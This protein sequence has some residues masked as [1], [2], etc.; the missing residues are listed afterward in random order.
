MCNKNGKMW[1][2]VIKQ[3]GA[4]EMLSVRKN[5][6]WLYKTIRKTIGGYMENVYPTGLPRGFVMIV[7]EEGKL[8]RKPINR[9]A[10]SLYEGTLFGDFI[11]GDV[12]ILKLGEHEGESDV[13]GIPDGEANELANKLKRK[14]LAF[15]TRKYEARP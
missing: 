12:I 9:F 13:V 6:E 5:G 2:V 14:S 1:A 8:K 3:N 4:M 10:S 15:V 7:D 11:V